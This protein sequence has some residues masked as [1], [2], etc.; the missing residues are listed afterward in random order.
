MFVF[1]GGEGRS[2]VIWVGDEDQALKALIQAPVPDH[3]EWP[4][5]LCHLHHL[6][7]AL[8]E[9]FMLR[10]FFRYWIIPCFVLLN[11]RIRSRTF[12]KEAEF[13][14]LERTAVHPKLL[15]SLKMVFS[16]QSLRNAAV[17][18]R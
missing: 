4:S 8:L 18:R 17:G 6:R 7:L 9:R 5:W 16:F 12:W 1:V 2:E 11:F 13:E 3:P 15:K 14:F 10:A